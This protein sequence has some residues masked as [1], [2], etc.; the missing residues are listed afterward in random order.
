MKN[1]L[2]R[3]LKNIECGIINLQNY[4]ESGS[5]WVAYYKN[6]DKKYYF[7]S[8]GDALPPKELDKYLGEE[9]VFL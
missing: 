4:N 3:K 8:Y 9:N 2:P 5:H 6:N 7:Y 1:E